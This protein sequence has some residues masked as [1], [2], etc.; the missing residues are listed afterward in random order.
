VSSGEIKKR[1]EIG[2]GLRLSVNKDGE[3]MDAEVLGTHNVHDINS[4]TVIANESYEEFARALQDEFH[5]IIKNRPKEIAP[6]LFEGQIF[7]DTSG[8]DLE[9]DGSKAALIFA[10]LPQALSK[11]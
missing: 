2:R 10:C 4:L 1:Q 9:I 5:E 6:S 7:T 3:R 8:N 11:I